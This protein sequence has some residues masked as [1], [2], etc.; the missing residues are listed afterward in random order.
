MSQVYSDA[1]IVKANGAEFYYIY[2]ADGRIGQGGYDTLLAFKEGKV[3]EHLQKCESE[4]AR[5]GIGLHR[6]VKA[7]PPAKVKHQRPVQLSLF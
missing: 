4:R 3:K 7:K 2:Y 1:Q 6:E 5:L